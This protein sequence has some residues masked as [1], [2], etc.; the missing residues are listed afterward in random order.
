LQIGG[1]SPGE[2]NRIAF[3][4]GNGVLVRSNAVGVTISGNSIFAKD[5]LGVNL[6]PPGEPANTVTPNDNLDS[7][8]GPNGLQNFPVITNTIYAGG[9]TVVS[10]YLRSVANED[11]DIELFVNAS[12][13]PS[14]YGEG[15]TYL[16]TTSVTTDSSGF[17]EFEFSGPGNF[18]AQVFT[19]TATRSSSGDTSEFS[20]AVPTLKG[21]LRI[22]DIHRSGSDIQISFTTEAGTNY[23]V[24]WTS[25]LPNANAWNTVSGASSVA[26]TGNV[27]SIK[28]LDVI[29]T[30]PRQRFYRIRQL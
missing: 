6:Q 24:E 12:S 20:G 11:F 30:A 26:G 1:T 23:R 17:A 29:G 8:S 2:A 5:G 4:H 25:Q 21:I 7:D 14:D 3:N 10:G 18:G 9:L 22:T 15:Q 19:A 16:D 28:D 27:V 13:D